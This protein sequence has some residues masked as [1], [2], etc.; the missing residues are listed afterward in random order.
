M[1]TPGAASGF[2][3]AFWLAGLLIFGIAPAATTARA[4]SIALQIDEP[5]M[6][7][8]ANT[9]SVG[10]TAIT[11][12]TL[13]DRW[14]AAFTN[15]A[16]FW[17]QTGLYGELALDAATVGDGFVLSFGPGT[18]DTLTIEL[19]GPLTDPILFIN[20]IDIVGARV[21]VSPGGTTFFSNPQGSWN[22]NVLTAV[23]ADAPGTFAAV[24]YTGFHRAGTVFTLHWDYSETSGFSSEDVAASLAIRVPESRA[25]SLLMLTSLALLLGRS[26]HRRSAA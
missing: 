18:S 13:N 8:G 23:A 17:N 9:G 10:S 16:T 20:D 15:D 2:G 11:A 21:T 22:G 24:Q 1:T 19:A 6:T 14:R 4:E 12:T 7:S 26:L 3:R 25:A 5:W